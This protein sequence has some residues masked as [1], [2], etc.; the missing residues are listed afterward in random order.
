[1]ANREECAKQDNI[2]RQKDTDL[3]HGKVEIVSVDLG[4]MTLSDCGLVDQ[5]GRYM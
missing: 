5:N 4:T 2:R 1:M 3:S